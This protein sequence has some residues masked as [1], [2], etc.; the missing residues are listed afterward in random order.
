M[1]RADKI[2]WKANGWIQVVIKNPGAQERQ[3][4]E[5]ALFLNHRLCHNCRSIYVRYIKRYFIRDNHKS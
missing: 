2:N 4:E 5:N 3:V 1:T